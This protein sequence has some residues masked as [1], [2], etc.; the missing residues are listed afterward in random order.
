M[1]IQDLSETP[2]LFIKTCNSRWLD[3]MLLFDDIFSS[4]ELFELML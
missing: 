1:I 2:Y 4:G 3:A